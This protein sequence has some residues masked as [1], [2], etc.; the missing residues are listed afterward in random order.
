[1]LSAIHQ[2][3]P[4]LAALG[5]FGYWIIA[6]AAALEAFLLT[7]IFIPGTLIVDAGGVMVQQGMLDPFDLIWFVAIGSIL[8]GEAS[9]WL[10]RHARHGMLGRWKVEEMKPYKRAEELFKRRGGVALVI[11]R[12]LGPVAAFVPF[13]AA[14]AGMERKKFGLWN[15]LSGFPYAIAHVGFGYAL[16]AG[17]T[18]F[19][20]LMTR[21]TLFFLALLVIA[22]VLYWTLRRLD[23]AI[24]HLLEMMGGLL[25]EIARH[26]RVDSWGGRH[27]RVAKWIARRLDRNHLAGLPLTLGVLAFVYL[28]ALLI[29]LSL[30]FLQAAPI[31]QIDAQLAELMRLFWT[32]GLIQIF[33]WITALGDTRLVVAVLAL[34][35]TWL[36]VLRRFDLFWGGL[37]ALGLDLVSV[38]ILK[39]GFSRP[40]SI[41]GYFQESSGSF[42][43]GHAALSVAFYGM[44]VFVLWRLTRLGAVSAGVL[45]VLF[46]G[47]IGLS[48]LYLVEHYLSDVMAGWILG[49]L[50]LLV[51]ISIA[52]WLRTRIREHVSPRPRWQ[53]GLLLALSLGLGGFAVKRVHDYSKAL[54]PPPMAEPLIQVAQGAN[55]PKLSAGSLEAQSLDAEHSFPLSLGIWAHGSTQIASA[56][57]TQGWTRAGTPSLTALM[58]AAFASVRD[59]AMPGAA[60]APLFWRNE[61]NVLGFS[62]PGAEAETQ[63]PR[64][65]LWQT[66]YVNEAGARLWLAVSTRDDGLLT[67]DAKH[68]ENIAT[69]LVDAL[70]SSGAAHLAGGITSKD[71]RPIPVLALN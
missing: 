23:R 69:A 33:I 20:P 44:L 52:E 5:I 10:G 48:R 60:L 61:P 67:D 63:I 3:L 62:K 39:A 57:E 58:R 47:L 21:N 71:S 22:A 12:F 6:A 49:A 40:R 35:L 45:A 27:P 30:N 14:L 2:V 41:L 42:P 54:N 13:A 17:L 8:G 34:A 43:S 18:T 11:G 64:L 16:G 66:P 25:D 53:I 31:V 68:A 15:I 26:P 7:G 28:F 55:L 56:L 46:A 38:V 1:M 4:S 32:P 19:S 50:C 29:G 36:A 24:P 70:R 59:K 37:V 65:R 51:G 9:W